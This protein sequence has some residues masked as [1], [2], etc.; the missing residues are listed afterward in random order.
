[1][2]FGKSNSLQHRVSQLAVSTTVVAVVVLTLASALISHSL[3][4]RKTASDLVEVANLVTRATVNATGA[5]VSDARILANMPPVSAL[6]R[7]ASNN[8]IDPKSGDSTEEWSDRLATVFT[9]F[10]ALRPNYIEILFVGIANGGREIVRVRKEGAEL[11]RLAEDQL[12]SEE[13]EPYFQEAADLGQGGVYIGQPAFEREIHGRQ[14]P[15]NLV[16][17]TLVPVFD[18]YGMPFGFIAIDTD[19]ISHNAATFD[20]LDLSADFLLSYSSGRTYAWHSD[21]QKGEFTFDTPTSLPREV[22]N[23]VE[24]AETGMTWISKDGTDYLTTQLDR[25]SHNTHRVHFTLIKPRFFFGHTL[26]VST[27]Q[28]FAL[29]LLLIIAAARY[30]QAGLKRALAPMIDMSRDIVSAANGGLD[31]VLPVSL[32]DEVGDLARSFR[33]LIDRLHQQE[34]H[35]GMVYDAVLDGLAVIDGDGAILN[36]NLSFQTAFEVPAGE[37]TGVKLSDFVSPEA[38]GELHSEITTFLSTGS[39][40][41]L[42]RGKLCAR[43]NRFGQEVTL[44]VLISPLPDQHPPLFVAVMRDVTARIALE[45]E[46]KSL[47]ERLN[48]SNSELEEFAYVASHDLKAPLRVISHAATWLEED[49]DGLLTD[50]TREHMFFMKSRI[51]R[52]ARLLDDLLLHSRIGSIEFDPS[53]QIVDGTAIVEDLEKLVESSEQI[54]LTFSDDFKSARLN[55]L[56]LRTVLLNLIGNAIKHNDKAQGE[57]YVSLH[58]SIGHYTIHV[59]DNGPGIP[60]KFHDLIFGLFKTLQSRDKVEGSGMGLAFVKKH[61]TILGHDI[62][63]ISDGSGQGTEFVFTWPKPVLTEGQD[64]A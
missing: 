46:A 5:I 62:R 20:P 52:M 10:H 21:Q 24:R 30:T 16:Y 55:F 53:R 51:Q 50:D 19:L 49:L 8:G 44:E 4:T 11:V 18:A 63:V 54:S 38:W 9:S 40:E 39:S 28:L 33:H 7:A 26:P 41:A 31:P 47:I 35:A 2:V 6:V 60:E 43:H 59:K 36:C 17:R 23:R 15:L 48:R 61:L 25:L 22:A 56:P 13:G 1:M 45:D 27:L 37:I 3:E 64:A 57:I 34:A 58:D 29:G 32:Q 12:R 42:G 14:T